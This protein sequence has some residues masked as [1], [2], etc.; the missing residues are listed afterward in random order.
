METK[1]MEDHAN[2]QRCWNESCVGAQLL[3]V[4]NSLQP[5]GTVALQTSLSV[6]FSRQ[7]YWS[8]L[9]CPPPGDLPDPGVEPMS[10]EFL[11]L[12]DGFFTTVPPG[13]PY[14]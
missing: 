12:A 8:E 3:V 2:K 5:P 13:K 4:P 7:E 11:A 10:P 6:G 1:I 9:P 14:S